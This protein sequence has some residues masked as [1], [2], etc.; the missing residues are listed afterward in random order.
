MAWPNPPKTWADDT[1]PTETEFNEQIRDALRYLK[2]LDGVPL[3]EDAIELKDKDG[4]PVGNLRLK[5]IDEILQIRNAA[6]DAFKKL[7]FDSIPVGTG[8]TEVAQGDHTH[9]LLEDTVDVDVSGAGT[10]SS[11]SCYRL[12]DAISP[13]GGLD[14]ASITDTYDANSRQVGVAVAKGRPSASA[15]FK[16]QLLMGGVVVAESAALGNVDATTVLIYT[17]VMSG[18][19]TSICRMYNANAS[20]QYIW[21]SYNEA[22]TTNRGG[23]VGVGSVRI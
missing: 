13:L 10:G 23:A 4:T 17:K 20:F 19:Q 21:Y 15:Q 5:V 8:A 11:L 12:S 6:D 7:K 16:L 3:F 14:L 22:A 1:V 2:G 9:S 18:S